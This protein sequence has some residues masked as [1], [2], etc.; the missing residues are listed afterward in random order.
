VTLK[1]GLVVTQGHRRLYH[2]IRYLWL[3]ITFHSNHRPISHL[4]RAKRRFRSKIAKF[5]HPRVFNAPANG[6]PVGIWYRRK[7]SQKLRWSGYQTLK[8]F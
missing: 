8:K 6:V 5:S 1:P 4:F 2:S 7:G 3:P